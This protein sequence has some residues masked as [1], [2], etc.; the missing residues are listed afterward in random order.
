M[1]QNYGNKYAQAKPVAVP[2]MV[3]QVSEAKRAR[4]FGNDVLV[5]SGVE[6]IAGKQMQMAIPNDTEN[7]KNNAYKPKAEPAGVAQSA[8]PGDYLMVESERKDQQIWIKKLTV[9][10]V[11]KDEELPGVF[12]FR[13]SFTK[14]DNGVDLQVVTLVKFGQFVDAMVPMKKN[15]DKTTSPDQAMTAAAN[16]FK[17][18]DVV[19]AEVAPGTPYAMLVSIDAHS[20]PELG[21]VREAG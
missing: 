16:S 2:P 6:P 12:V 18:D 4:F 21:Q 3:I 7:N 19:D 9:Y 8:K 14:R 1:Q 17:K 15:E 5:V 10:K 20:A 11:A 13:E